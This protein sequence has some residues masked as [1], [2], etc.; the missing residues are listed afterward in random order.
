MPCSS[1]CAAGTDHKEKFEKLQ[2]V[3][4]RYRGERAL[5]PVLQEAQGDLW[6]SYLDV[7]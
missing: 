7:Q 1:T 3:L 2:E 6:R 5:M 4:R